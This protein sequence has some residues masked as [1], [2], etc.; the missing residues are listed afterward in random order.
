MTDKFF[1]FDLETTGLHVVNDRIITAAVVG[2]FLPNGGASLLL[3]PGIRI[4]AEASAVHGIT[5]E[6]A[7]WGWTTQQVSRCSV[8]CSLTPGHA[9]ARWLVTT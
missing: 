6:K 8:T 4:S 3:N 1:A 7:A 9:A 5:D 2:D